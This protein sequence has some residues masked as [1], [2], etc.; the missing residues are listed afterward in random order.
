MR[1]NANGQLTADYRGSSNVCDGFHQSLISSIWDN[2]YD[3]STN[4]KALIGDPL[5]S[6]SLSPQP[7]TSNAA[8]FWG[9]DLLNLLISTARVTVRL[10]I[11]SF[12]Y[13]CKREHSELYSSLSVM[14]ITWC[15]DHAIKNLARI[16]QTEAKNIARHKVLKRKLRCLILIWLRLRLNTD[17]PITCQWLLAHN[18]QQPIDWSI[19]ILD[20]KQQDDETDAYSGFHH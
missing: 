6:G 17:R 20:Y 7:V 3:F 4:R 19:P 15:Y 16:T 1:L 14:S 13:L 10:L 18:D 12:S 9:W 5:W 2:A 8:D 11:I